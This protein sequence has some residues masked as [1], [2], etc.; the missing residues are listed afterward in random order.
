MSGGSPDGH[1]AT[2]VNALSDY[3]DALFRPLPEAIDGSPSPPPA[4]PAGQAVNGA[5]EQESTGAMLPRDGTRLQLQLLD[6]GGL[7]L[8]L[9][10]E[11]LAGIQHLP[12]DLDLA[13]DREQPWLLGIREENGRQTV[14]VDTFSLVVPSSHRE[15]IR[16]SGDESAR[17][18]AMVAGGR[19][20]LVCRDRG[21]VL[22]VARDAVNWRSERTRHPWVSGT[23]KSERCALLDVETFVKWLEEGC[24]GWA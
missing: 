12:E 22:D 10:V 19:W 23:L 5:Q 13:R 3:L 17:Q 6:L 16:R 7:A 1:D 8:A 2:P 21:R 20:G 4:D 14:L 24:P 9:P 15:R 18:V 11:Q